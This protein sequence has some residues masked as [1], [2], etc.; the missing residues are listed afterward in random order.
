MYEL[1]IYKNRR[2]A[3]LVTSERRKAI[4]PLRNF[5]L[6]CVKVNADWALVSNRF[7]VVFPGKICPGTTNH[8]TT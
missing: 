2:R 3:N 4:I 1:G 6:N 5:V 7:G 8:P